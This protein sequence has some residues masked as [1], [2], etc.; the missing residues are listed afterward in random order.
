MARS[1]RSVGSRCGNRRHGWF[2]WRQA[3]FTPDQETE[4][5]VGFE[6]VGTETR[7]TVEHLGWDEIPREHAARHGFPLLVF[8][9]RHAE[10]WQTL[11]GRLREHVG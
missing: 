4:V 5:R 9:Q 6:R 11:L 10:W 7:V 2:G 3:S 1:S 8:Q